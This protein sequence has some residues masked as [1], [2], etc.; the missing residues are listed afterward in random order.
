M[1][2]TPT[3]LAL[4]RAFAKALL[5]ERHADRFP[6]P[7]D[8]EEHLT[9]YSR[10][11]F[12]RRSLQAGAAVYLGGILGG[13]TTTRRIQNP[14]GE[15]KIAVVGGG[16]AGLTAA[17]HLRRAGYLSTVYEASNR[18]GGRMF[19]AQDLLGPG[20]VTEL[21]G[22]YIDSDHKYIFDL[23]KA[24]DLELLDMHDD[25][26]AKTLTE[27]A[28]HIKGQFYKVPE[29]VA[30]FRPVVA[31]I[32]ADA[33][34]VSDAI[35]YQSSTPHDQ[36]LDRQS[37]AEYLQGLDLTGWFY[38]LLDVA[39]TSEM[40]SEIDRQSALNLIT[41]IGT[42]PDEFKIF[43]SSDERYKVKG[44][45]QQI[46]DRLAQYLD[47]QLQTGYALEALS[48]KGN[49]YS[50][51]FAN[52]RDA[53]ADIVILTLPFTQLRKVDLR[54]E[55]PLV[56]RRAINEL[57]YG[58]NSKLLLG[59]NERVWR[60]A[61]YAGYLFDGT[62]QN[63]WDNTRMQLGNNGPGGYTV[64]L[65]GQAGK[66]LAVD[67]A[68]RYLT[69]ID[70]VFPGAQSAANA[71]RAVFNWPDHAFTGGSYACY[72]VGQWTGIGGAEGEPV[73]RL[74]FAGEHCSSDYVGFMN[75][76]AE[77]GTLAAKAVLRTMKVKL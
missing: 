63:G 70:K 52:G 41:F 49:G 7:D 16:I 58:T 57:G 5:L 6:S 28:F 22:E 59:M 31:K 66:N 42:D 10:R 45:N 14:N 65:G 25:P 15:V 69:A 34:A 67:Q 18:T 68:G 40:G 2:K 46:T 75:G 19:S 3:A 23:I 24:F 37:L 38:E 20:L 60:R 47:G 76:G 77:T 51:R 61:G 62:V 8:L 48:A 54:V 55:L 9:N 32:A 53:D 43:G 13:C 44:G 73:G 27:E 72:D 71:K 36:A 29:L 21:G 1:L 12:L 11:Q 56:K 35:G 30:A 50:L 33:Q 39:Y 26:A 64:F 17:Y 74:F 4:R